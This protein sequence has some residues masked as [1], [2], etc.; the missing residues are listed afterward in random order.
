[1]KYKY[2]YRE[3]DIINLIKE[4]INEK[5]INKIKE[6]IH[7]FEKNGKMNN[8]LLKIKTLIDEY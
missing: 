4:K 8:I 6:I 5:N 1:M 7:D 3:D 2:I